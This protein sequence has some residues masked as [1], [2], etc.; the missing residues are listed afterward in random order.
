MSGDDRPGRN[1][2]LVHWILAYVKV[3]LLDN[4]QHFAKG[5]TLKREDRTRGDAAAHFVA[6][7]I[8]E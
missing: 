2:H 1:L 5:N 6:W 7:H 3:Y 4:L 8:V